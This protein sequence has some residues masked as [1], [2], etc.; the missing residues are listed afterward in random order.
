MASAQ[1]DSMHGN[2]RGTIHESCR[3]FTEIIVS[4]HDSRSILA[5]SI[6]IDGVGLMATLNT[7]SCPVLMP[8]KIHPQLLVFVLIVKLTQDV[9]SVHSVTFSVI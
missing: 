9:Q 2:A 8:P 3:P 1:T 4:L 6:A 7:I 5:C